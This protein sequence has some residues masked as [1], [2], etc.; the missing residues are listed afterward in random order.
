ML[1]GLAAGFAVLMI[2]SLALGT[3]ARLGNRYLSTWQLLGLAV[4][5]LL[6]GVL[7]GVRR[8]RILA[9][10]PRPHGHCPK[11]GYDLTGN[12]SGVC[13]ECGG[14]VSRHDGHE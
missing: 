14:A 10:T 13:P 6:I 1:E 11:C 2:V 8:H 3:G 7:A 5:S 4:A 9:R 12:T